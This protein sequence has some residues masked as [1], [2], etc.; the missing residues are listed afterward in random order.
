MLGYNDAVC[1]VSRA[2]F[3]RADLEVPIWM[4]NLQCTRRETALDQ[5]SFSGWGE[6]FCNHGEDAGVICRDGKTQVWAH[7]IFAFIGYVVF[8]A[9][10]EGHN[11]GQSCSAYL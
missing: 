6:N 8:S 7:T 9:N 3:G 1:A 11:G 4:S 2:Q 10:W 5:C